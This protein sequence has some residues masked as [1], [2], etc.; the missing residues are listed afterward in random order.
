MVK[1]GIFKS[2][3][4]RWLEKRGYNDNHR[5]RIIIRRED[6][7]AREMFEEAYDQLYVENRKYAIVPEYPSSI[8]VKEISGSPDI[9]CI[10]NGVEQ[11]FEVKTDLEN[12]KLDRCI[13]QCL[14]YLTEFTW[15]DR[16]TVVVPKG[17]EGVSS[18]RRIISN[19]N[20]PIQVI[21]LALKEIP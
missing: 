8:F 20:L 21:E 18:L 15:I 7:R 3:V 16:I 1:E 17:V 4:K 9:R 5:S 2:I 6:S 13:G 10:K 19:F 11:I 14:R 12:E